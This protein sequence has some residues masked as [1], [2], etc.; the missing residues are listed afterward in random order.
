MFV[1]GEDIG[2]SNLKVAYGRCETG[3]C[4]V[5]TTPATAVPE[6]DMGPS[7]FGRR[8]DGT[9]VLVDGA[10]WVVGRDVGS[11]IGGPRELHQDYTRSPSWRALL[12]AGL[13]HAGADYVDRLVLGLPVSQFS[14]TGIKTHLKNTLPGVHQ[15]TETRRIQVSKVVVIPQPFGAYSDAVVHDEI[16]RASHVPLLESRVLAIDPGWFSVDWVLFDNASYRPD[17]SGSAMEAVSFLAEEIA[18]KLKRAMNYAQDLYAIERMLRAGKTTMGIRGT[19]TDMT[20]FIEPAIDAVTSR[21]AS[22]IRNATRRLGQDVDMVSMDSVGRA[23]FGHQVKAMRQTLVRGIGLARVRMRIA[24]ANLAY[25][26]SRLV[27]L[28]PPC[29]A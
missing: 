25:N 17:A 24:L 15:I 3:K 12:Y 8:H 2:Y 19:E 14:D 10:P 16:N 21:V 28:R 4:A 27:Q 26:M 9:R 1:V 22:T 6:A 18:K 20:P 13:V 29:A 5:T 11:A 23:V 7:F